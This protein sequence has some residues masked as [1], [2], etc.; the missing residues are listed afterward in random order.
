MNIPFY[1][2]KMQ[3]LACLGFDLDSLFSFHRYAFIF[4]H[5]SD[6][7]YSIFEHSAIFQIQMQWEPVTPESSKQFNQNLCNSKQLLKKNNWNQIQDFK[8]FKEYIPSTS[9]NYGGEV[10]WSYIKPKSHKKWIPAGKKA[11]K[12]DPKLN[13]LSNTYFWE[14]RNILLQMLENFT[15]ENALIIKATK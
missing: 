15:D 1:E 6:L 7:I 13:M 11:D 3:Q 12:S 10:H 8:N 2:N 9:L 5:I 14:R 4:N